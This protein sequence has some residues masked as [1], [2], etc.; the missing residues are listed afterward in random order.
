MTNGPLKACILFSLSMML[1][2]C[3]GDVPEVLQAPTTADTGVA[4]S[5]TGSV[6]TDIANSPDLSPS[7]LAAE[8]PCSQDS[9]CTS[10]QCVWHLGE[11]VCR[12]L[13]DAL[14]TGAW[15]CINGVCTSQFPSICK[16]CVN[17]TD[18][19]GNPNGSECVH[20]DG[21]GGFC[22]S[23]CG[24]SADCPLGWGCK[25]S[26]LT[27][28]GQSS[29][30]IPNNGLCECS[31]AAVNE[32]L[33]AWCDGGA[34][35]CAGIRTC[36][37]SGL[38][39]CLAGTPTAEVCNG[40][41]DD[42]D[43]IKDEGACDDQNDCTQDLCNSATGCSHQPLNGLVCGGLC[44]ANGLCD[45]G[46]CVGTATLDCNDNDPCTT[47]TCDPAVG[48]IHTKEDENCGTPSACPGGASECTPGEEDVDTQACGACGS[49]TRTRYCTEQC[50]WTSWSQWSECGSS[51]VCSP[52]DTEQEFQACGS[53]GS[54]ERSRTCTNAC[55]W[56][57]WSSWSACDGGGICTPGQSE[58]DTQSCGNCG[59][60]TRTRFCSS[61]CEWGSWGSWSSC[62]GQGSCSPGETQSDSQSCGNCGNQTRNRTCNGSCSW[63]SWSAWG[64]CSSQGACA[65]GDTTDSDCDACAEKTCTSSCEWS[66]CNLKPGAQCLHQGGTNWQ[67]CGSG[68]WQFCLGPNY[69][70]VWSDQCE[71]CTG[72]GC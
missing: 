70:C 54:Q 16:P 55:E 33:T 23:A 19:T 22:G 34:S 58:S 61:Q 68:K 66:Q 43:G 6:G 60:Q 67:C 29:Q 1:M 15:S 27:A 63:N 37:A 59:S 41:D 31:G 48:C 49:Q 71:T 9:Q 52:G 72:C 7:G 2:S 51:S 8:Q 38:G 24:T 30:C 32:Q 36:T 47:D 18:C 14:C 10:G 25:T 35:G 46:E 12:P 5:D 3:G 62:S 42:C 11:K 4:F 13:C 21:V 57:A 40:A 20:F 44:V 26:Y 28:G 65:P 53:C 64:Q 39:P 45:N 56:G 17:T 69:G 50:T